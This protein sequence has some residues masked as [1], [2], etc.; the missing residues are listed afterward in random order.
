MPYRPWHPHDVPEPLVPGQPVELDVEI[1]PTSVI[2][3]AGYRIGVT[4]LGRDLELPGEGPWPTLLGVAMRGNGA[5]V[6]ADQR[7]RPAEIFGGTTTLLSGGNQQSY[8]VLPSIP[9]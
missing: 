9:C 6:H 2:V 8:V 7:D 5:F 1:W 4:I 3:P